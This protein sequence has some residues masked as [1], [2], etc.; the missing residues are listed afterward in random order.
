[1]RGSWDVSGFCLGSHGERLS[2]RRLFP[3]VGANPERSKEQFVVAAK[4][5]LS[6]RHL[7]FAEKQ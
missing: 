5:V 7:R 3:A 2:R 6:P 1:M 4:T